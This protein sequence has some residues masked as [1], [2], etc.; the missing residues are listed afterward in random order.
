[1]AV[2]YATMTG[3]VAGITGRDNISIGASN[4]KNLTS[5]FE[6]I[7]IGSLCLYENTSG[8][9]NIAI[10]GGN[11]GG[12]T[13]SA[14]AYNT[15]GIDNVVVGRQALYSNTTGSNN[16]ASGNSV[17]RFNTTGSN[18]T[19]VGYQS[20]YSNTTGNYN[21]ALGQTAGTGITTG[22]SNISIGYDCLSGTTTGSNN[23][24][25]GKHCGD[26]GVTGSNNMALG[27]RAGRSDSPSGNITSGSNNICIGDNNITN[28]Y[29]ADTSISSSDGRDKTDIEDFTAGLDF[30]TQM[31]PVTYR[32]DKRTSYVDKDATSQDVLNVVPDGTHKKPK[33]HIGFISQE[34]QALEQ[35]L[36]FATDKDNELI[37]NTNE[38]A[39]A[40]GLK[41]ERLVPILVNAIKELSAKVEALENA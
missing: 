3:A 37:C 20:L 41:Y 26:S 18:N 25:V 39:T 17:L 24:Y 32:W 22:S 14:M 21:T 4:L 10:G 36:G 34:V 23:T 38:D 8:Y 35:S 6:N 19:A 11:T 27:N 16:V 2:G 30:I 5:G 1:V 13:R 7:A 33:Q 31:R 12:G 15:T 40:M 28:L 29:C 9:R